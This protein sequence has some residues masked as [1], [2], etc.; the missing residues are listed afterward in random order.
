MKGLL[1]AVVVLALAALAIA[2]GGVSISPL[3]W[4]NAGS[5]TASIVQAGADTSGS[6]S[7]FRGRGGRESFV[8]R[9]GVNINT[10]EV[11]DSTYIIISLDISPDGANWVAYSNLDTLVTANED[12]YKFVDL[13]SLPCAKYGRIRITGKMAAG[14][15]VTVTGFVG[16]DYEE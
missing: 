2:G 10:T 4:Q 5:T 8:E 3:Y 12:V 6:F 16:L 7:L 9:L 13:T 15:T 11:N 1:V 14:D